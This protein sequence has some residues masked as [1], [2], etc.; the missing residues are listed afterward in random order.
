MVTRDCKS[1]NK[2]LEFFKTYKM[3]TNLGCIDYNKRIKVYAKK[4]E[5][6]EE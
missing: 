3:C 2:S 1:C 5:T 6:E 4:I